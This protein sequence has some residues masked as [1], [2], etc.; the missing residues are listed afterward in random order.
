MWGRTRAT[1]IAAVLAARAG[2]HVQVAEPGKQ[3]CVND[4]CDLK[5]LLPRGARMDRTILDDPLLADLE[6]FGGEQ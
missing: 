1:W 4:I 5:S 2:E 6:Q 3:A